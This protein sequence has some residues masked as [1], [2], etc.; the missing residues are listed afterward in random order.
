MKLSNETKD[1]LKTFANINSNIAIGDPGILRTVAISKN[2]MAKATITDVF[3]YKFGVYDLNEFL[4]C[5]N[6]FED[7]VLAF[8]DSR[9]FVKITDGISSI[10]YFF[11]DLENLTVSDRD[12]DIPTD[13]VEFTITAD[14]LAS[15]RKASAALKANDLVVT[16]N[17]DGGTF[18]KLT[19][20]DKDNP[21]SNEFDINIANCKINIEEQFEFVYNVNNFKF[22]SADEFEFGIS[23]K[24]ISSVKA[25]DTNFWVALE[26]TSKVGV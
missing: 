4:S 12:I 21:T 8:D 10:K 22:N 2:L 11:S 18:I 5:V 13:N 7:P 19:V 24:L 20:T 1:V 23:T 9:K 25:G 3:P 15:I 16:K 17:T 14:Q 26:K 6:M